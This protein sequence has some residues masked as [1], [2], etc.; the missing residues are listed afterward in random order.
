MRDF[1]N[2]EDQSDTRDGTDY[3]ANGDLVIPVG[4][5]NLSLSGYVVHTDRTET[6][7]SSEYED[8]TTVD[9]ADLVT[10]ADQFEDI[11]Q[12]NYTLSAA[13]T[14]TILKGETEFSVDFT[15]FNEDIVATENESEFDPFPTLDDFGGTRTFSKTDDRMWMARFDHKRTLGGVVDLE[16]GVDFSDK[17]RE[18]HITEAEI[19]TPGDPFP[20]PETIDGRL[21][22]DRRDARGP[23]RHVFPHQWHPRMGSGPALRNDEFQGHRPRHGR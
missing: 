20:D 2:R 1:D 15:K 23:V 13:L 9:P 5:G 6:E 8:E 11:T 16:F 21:L 14:Q 12:D 4:M 18:G 10:Q 17:V 3:S 7:L 22:Q 19:D